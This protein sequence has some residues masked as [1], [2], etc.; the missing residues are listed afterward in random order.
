MKTE[1]L[2]QLL[3]FEDVK[4]RNILPDFNKKFFFVLDEFDHECE[5][6]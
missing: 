5:K 6:R 4:N 1:Q 3:L 2:N